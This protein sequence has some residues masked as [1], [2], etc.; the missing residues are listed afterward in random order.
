MR[1]ERNDLITE[2]HEVLSRHN[3]G[4]DAGRGPSR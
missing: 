2:T 4:L 3:L 1:F